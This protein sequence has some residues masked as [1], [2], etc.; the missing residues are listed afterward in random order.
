MKSYLSRYPTSDVSAVRE[1]FNDLAEKA[2]KLRF[3]PAVLVIDYESRFSEETIRK[4]FLHCTGRQ[5]HAHRLN[6]LTKTQ[7]LKHE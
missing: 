3:K 2:N 7:I 6:L 5:I 1:Q 4:V